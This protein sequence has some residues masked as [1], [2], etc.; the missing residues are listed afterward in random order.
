MGAEWWWGR[1]GQRLMAKR[2]PLPY[3][4]YAVKS[5]RCRRL[6]GHRGQAGGGGADPGRGELWDSGE[7]D[8]PQPARCWLEIGQLASQ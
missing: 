4:G 1:R 3:S 8:I 2:N 7:S 6:R 5:P